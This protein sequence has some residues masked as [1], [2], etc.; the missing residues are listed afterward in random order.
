[1][2]IPRSI[3]LLKLLIS[4]QEL[5][6]IPKLIPIRESILIP[7]PEQIAIPR[8]IPI[9]IP[10][11]IPD[12]ELTLESTLESESIPAT[13]SPPELNPNME[14]ESGKSDSELPPLV[15]T[16]RMVTSLHGISRPYRFWHGN[17]PAT[18][19]QTHPIGE[20]SFTNQTIKQERISVVYNGAG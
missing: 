4:I 8:S 12:L 17:R 3:L 9:L 18:I 11:P 5:I 7:F 1:M 15:Y 2:E 20:C 13:E 19:A 6:L 10:E 14:S 16:Q